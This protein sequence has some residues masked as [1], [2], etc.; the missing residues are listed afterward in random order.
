M[1]LKQALATGTVI[2]ALGA[3]AG[4]ALLNQPVMADTMV[5][6]QSSDAGVLW[7]S[8]RP[9]ADGGAGSLSL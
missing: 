3:G 9:L 6:A 1:T 2:G 8:I 4:I 5:N 7:G